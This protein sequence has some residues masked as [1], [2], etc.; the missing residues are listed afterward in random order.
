MCTNTHYIVYYV[1]NRCSVSGR[2]QNTWPIRAKY[3][4]S[5]GSRSRRR[6]WTVSYSR[7]EFW[8]FEPL[9]GFIFLNELQHC[10]IRI[11]LSKILKKHI[12]VLTPPPLK[13]NSIY[14][15]AFD[16]VVTIEH[17]APNSAVYNNSCIVRHAYSRRNVMWPLRY[18]V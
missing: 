6:R 8:G 2:G 7:G 4:R 5:D 9:P 18:Y 11:K 12:I 15:T 3:I 10:E 13:L 14:A 17:H 1:Y 16:G